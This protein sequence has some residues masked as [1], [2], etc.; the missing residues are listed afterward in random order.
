MAQRKR[1]QHRTIGKGK[2]KNP[3]DSAGTDGAIEGQSQVENCTDR[4]SRAKRAAEQAKQKQIAA[5]KQAETT[6]VLA[7]PTKVIP[8]ARHTRA[9][10][11]LA[12]RSQAPLPPDTTSQ[13]LLTQD[14]LAISD[15]PCELQQQEGSCW[16]QVTVA[17]FFICSLTV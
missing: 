4:V 10:T 3:A 16:S 17:C 6:L 7:T 11:E 1:K 9:S 5:T 8:A 14:E 13:A 12:A 15:E 2:R